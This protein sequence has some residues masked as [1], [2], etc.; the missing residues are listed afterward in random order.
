MTVKDNVL[1][2]E[3]NVELIRRSKAKWLDKR[4]Q[5]MLARAFVSSQTTFNEE[6]YERLD[7]ALKKE[8]GFF[9]Q[10]GQPV[11]GSIVGL[12][13]ANDQASESKAKEIADIYQAI[14]DGGFKS[15]PFTYFGAYLLLFADKQDRAAF[16]TKGQAV[17]Q[18]IKNNHPF[19]TGPEDGPMALS[20]VMQDTLKNES[21]TAI[22]N[23]MER[24]YEGLR[25][26]GFH[27]QNELQFA[28]ATAAMVAPT[29]S[30]ELLRRVEQ[31][32]QEIKALG[33][34]F[35]PIHYNVIVMLAFASLN[36]KASIAVDLP[37]YLDEME[38]HTKLKFQKTFRQTLALSLY[39]GDAI[40]SLSTEA[41]NALALNLTLML[42]Q[43][44]MV[45][46]AAT[47]TMVVASSS[48]D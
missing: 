26:I 45:M 27:R 8:T 24:Y 13:M 46:I 16:I 38:A 22:V 32:V 42:I 18:E 47:T 5:Y 40:S 34:R 23:L 20:I 36:G 33:I 14:R 35:Q 37:I 11:R 28:A 44:E 25:E 12:M 9:S 7:T 29:F 1:K 4:V 17:Y 39:V 43:E 21:A 48:N 19:L 31:V 6:K 30:P 10:L 15:S 3:K 41:V 2:L